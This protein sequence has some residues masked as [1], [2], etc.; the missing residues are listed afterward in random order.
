MKRFATLGATVVL[1]CLGVVSIIE[2]VLVIVTKDPTSRSQYL[3]ALIALPILGI[4]YYLT[5]Q[6]LGGWKVAT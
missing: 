2:L 3:A 1:I 5:F 6:L 4:I